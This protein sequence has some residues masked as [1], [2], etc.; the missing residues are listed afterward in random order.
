MSL[1]QRATK[2]VFWSAIERFSVQ[3]IQ[4][5]ISIILARLLFPADFGLL[6]LVFIVINVL[7]TINEVGFGAS[8]MYKQDRDDLDFSSVFILNIFMG[9]F[10]YIIL[11]FT[12]PFLAVFFTQPQLTL[13]TRITGISLIINSFVVVQRTKLLIEVDFKTQAKAS[14]IAVLFSGVIGILAAFKGY[15]VWS[16]VF[17]ILVSSV[18]NVLL[19]WK[20]VKWRPRLL[21]SYVRFLFLFKFAY[22]LILARL[23]NTIFE[24]F[25]SLVIGKVYTPAQLG[26]FNRG[27][28]FILL[29][30]H[31]LTGII[32]RVS[33]PLLCEAQNDHKQMGQILNKFISSTALIVYPILFGLF[34]LAE[35]LISVVLTDKWL[36]SV[37]ILQIFCPVGI[38][39]VINTFNRNVFNATG[40]TDLALR[41]EIIKKI[42][43]IIIVL[44]SIRLG[45]TALLIS[46]IFI[47][48]IEL[49]IETYYTKKQIG[50][51]LFQQLNSIKS[52]FFASVVM[53]VIIYLSTYYMVSG[54][55]KL[56]SGTLIGFVTY[57]ILC[58]IF[59]IGN[60][61]VYFIKII[62]KL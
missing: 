21:F 62:K 42:L 41:T 22:K 36:P 29:T 11:Y 47:A 52:I 59:N 13:I 5:V 6:A 46:Q 51:T 1:K 16:L 35:P 43:F 24:Q 58:Y 12:A 18:L 60:S 37:P 32:Q 23:I 19:I 40:R 34:I 3:G 28:S 7:Q 27:Q 25:Y 17:Q 49:F 2:G 33:T 31:N 44:F 20:F 9:V 14:L 56:M 48:I 30:S 53:G 54:F 4:F 57:S 45:F 15:G 55:L 38:L 10:L 26:F 8:L 61:R 39:Y 50:L